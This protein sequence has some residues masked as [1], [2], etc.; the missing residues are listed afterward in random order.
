MSGDD[1]GVY[2]DDNY[3]CNAIVVLKLLYISRDLINLNTENM[4]IVKDIT[5]G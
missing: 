3:H 5:G 4:K 2:R 1:L